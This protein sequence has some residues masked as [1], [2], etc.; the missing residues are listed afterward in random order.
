MLKPAWQVFVPRSGAAAL[1]GLAPSLYNYGY[2]D[3]THRDAG[4]G[5]A[6]FG[7]AGFGDAGFGS[8]IKGVQ[9]WP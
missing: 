5:D 1:Y 6:G 4:F 8:V 9:R 3:P 2:N 7:D